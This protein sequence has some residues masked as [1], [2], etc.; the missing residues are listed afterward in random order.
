MIIDSPGL[1]DP[2]V[3]NLGIPFVI[4]DNI[5]WLDIPMDD[6]ILMNLLQSQNGTA[7]NELRLTFREPFLLVQMLPQIASIHQIHHDVQ[8]VS[9]LKSLLNCY[10][11]WIVKTPQQ[12]VLIHH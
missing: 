2:K 5:L 1:R 3:S 7:Y 9:I 4:K 6:P 11:K 12:M 8:I 10:Y